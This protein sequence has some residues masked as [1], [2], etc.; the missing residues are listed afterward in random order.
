MLY[1]PPNIKPWTPKPKLMTP[2]VLGLANA[3]PAAGNVLT[4]APYFPTG[5]DPDNPPAGYY[6]ATAADGGDNGNAGTYASPWLDLSYACGQ[7]EGQGSNTLYVKEGS[8]AE[9]LTGNNTW[10][11]LNDLNTDLTIRG[12]GNSGKQ[13]QITLTIDSGWTVQEGCIYFGGAVV[14]N[15]DFAISCDVASNVTVSGYPKG[16]FHHGASLSP[17]HYKNGSYH[18]ADTGAGYSR[19]LFGSQ[20]SGST[21]APHTTNVT[22]IIDRPA[23]THFSAFVV[24]KGGNNLNTIIMGGPLRSVYSSSFAG[25]MDYLLYEAIQFD[26]DGTEGSQAILRKG[27]RFDADYGTAVY[28]TKCAAGQAADRFKYVGPQEIVAST[29]S[30]IVVMKDS[31]SLSNE[32][33]SMIIGA[34]LQTDEWNVGT[35]SYADNWENVADPSAGVISGYL[36]DDIKD[37]SN[38]E[39]WVAGSPLPSAGANL[40]HTTV[41]Y[42]NPDGSRN[43]LGKWG[44]PLAW[45]V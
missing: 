15:I 7:L 22:C 9:T 28:N 44:G 45:L 5:F 33:E 23:G 13:P 34:A 26:S 18:L 35:G 40:G 10:I 19:F 29:G 39:Y 31:P 17:D 24:V 32:I 41:S 16:F 12:Y 43:N 1:L 2:S 6:I 25:D 36:G 3:L 42:N 8:Y 38:A 14:D 27:Q 11:N 20:V 30:V 21:Y 4:A 37:Y